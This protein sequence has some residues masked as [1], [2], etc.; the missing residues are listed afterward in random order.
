[1]PESRFASPP[2]FEVVGHV[3]EPTGPP[4]RIAA[5]LA[6]TPVAFAG[7]SQARAPKGT[8]IGGQWIETA[9]GLLD[10]IT[11]G[12]PSGGSPGPLVESNSPMQR[13]DLSEGDVAALRASYVSGSH[14]DE[15]GE[16]TPERKELHEAI[17]NDFLSGV[18]PAPEG[19]AEAFFNG[20]G[21]GSGKSSFTSGTIDAGY[22]PTRGVNDMTGEMDFAGMPNPGA[23]LVDPDSIKM[24]LPEVKSMRESLRQDGNMTGG[25]G[26]SW[27]SESHEESSYIAKMVYAEAI[28]RNLPVVYDGTGTKI[29]GKAQEAL[30][31]G[32][33]SV[34]ANY[35]YVEPEQ[36]LVSAIERAGRIGRNVPPKLQANQYRDMP[37]AFDAVSKSGIF[38]E[39]NL[40][41]RNGVSKGESIPK[42]FEVLPSG[43]RKILDQ[44]AYDRF[45]SSGTRLPDVSGL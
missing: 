26:A 35:M 32:Y 39:V 34:K 37:A 14:I 30:D 19:E 43:E 29:I 15:N 21:P 44:A 28:R 18:E 38:K 2:V 6:T 11:G 8:I 20:G 16:W 24:Q 23:A 4:P 10:R 7:P 13:P 12:G 42:I 31:G 41:D 3:E 17:V 27:A 25:V 1:M 40:F 36:A 5:T 9:R 45:L 33:K 22:P